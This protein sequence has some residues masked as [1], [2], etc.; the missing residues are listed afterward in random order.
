M[1]DLTYVK[2]AAESI[3]PHLKKGDLVVVESTVS[4]GACV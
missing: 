1:A 2:S 3:V 4:P